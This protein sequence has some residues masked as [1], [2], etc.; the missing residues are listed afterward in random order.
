M[1]RSQFVIWNRLLHPNLKFWV[2]KQDDIQKALVGPLHNISMAMTETLVITSCSIYHQIPSTTVSLLSLRIAFTKIVGQVDLMIWI[3]V[4]LQK[5]YHR[6]HRESILR[7]S[8]QVM[9][10][11]FN[12]K[13]STPELRALP[14]VSSPHQSPLLISPPLPFNLPPRRHRWQC[15]Y[16]KTWP[17][18]FCLL[19][20]VLALLNSANCG[21]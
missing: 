13:V 4:R 11:L 10:P 19:V 6:R 18:D 7:T 3:I 5:G 21:Q 8:K 14:E 15:S 12:R 9:L 2:R 20:N 1:S 16:W 17:A